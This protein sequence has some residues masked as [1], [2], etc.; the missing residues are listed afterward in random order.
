MS[1]LHRRDLETTPDSR[2]PA[3]SSYKP[4]RDDE[5]DELVASEVVST[6]H[7]FRSRLDLLC[8]DAEK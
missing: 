5:I 6:L 2:R 3:K 7:E 1:Y 8:L 4:Y